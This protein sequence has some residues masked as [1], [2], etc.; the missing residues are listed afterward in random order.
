MNS[1]FT[2]EWRGFVRSRLIRTL[3]VVFVVS[4]IL[5]TWLGARQNNQQIEAQRI[6][7][8]HVRAQWDE[9]EPSNPHRA[10]HFG[11][12]AFKPT[13]ILNS[14]DEGI[15]SVTGNVLRLEGHTQNDVMFS[16][17]SQSLVMS[18]FGK[19]K[20]SLLFQFLIPLFLIFLSFNTY[21]AERESGR[22]KI[23]II[24]GASLSKIVF[25]KV[26]SIWVIGLILLLLTTCTQLFFN[27]AHLSSEIL[28]RLFFLVSSYGVY[29]LILINLTVALS[30]WLKNGTV[31][32]SVMVV[33]WVTW[34]IFFPK[35]VGN[36][37]EQMVPLPTR[38]EFQESMSEDRVQGIDGHNPS[39]ERK[40]KL[41]EATLQQYNVQELSELPI[42]FAGIV[43]QADEEYGN[44]V[45][46][47]HFGALYA[48]MEQQ[49]KTV[50]RSGV[51]NPFIAVHSLSMG[52]AG[53]DMFHHLDFLK[54]AEDYRRVFIKTLNDEYA[55]GGSKTGER[56]WKADTAF[57]QSVEDFRYQRPAF[58][59]LSVKYLP[60]VFVLMIWLAGSFAVLNSLS[61]RASVL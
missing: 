61:K 19:L 28:Q 44:E 29:Y 17:A 41:E 13:S 47:K 39:D 22:L 11:S 8:D 14:M 42:N 54:K 53:T 50:Q 27:T 24:Q 34:T 7:Q 10:A 55:F 21:A 46:D 18:K 4:L 6:A 1:I 25:S 58:S 12:Y 3:S 48:Q 20:P 43:M 9:M 49:K 36:A 38:I 35:I 45:W 52:A 60:D 57:F 56:G 26:L 40:K 2:N 59:T 16:E 51:L 15:N 23:L 33:T 37:V 5:V 31:S 32:M 30:L